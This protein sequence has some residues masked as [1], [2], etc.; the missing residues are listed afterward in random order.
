MRDDGGV[1][2]QPKLCRGAPSGKRAR[3][4]RVRP[5]TR[6]YRARDMISVIGSVSAGEI[7]TGSS[8]GW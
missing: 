2:R 4:R 3:P 7:F 8:I 6:R 5:G 1:T